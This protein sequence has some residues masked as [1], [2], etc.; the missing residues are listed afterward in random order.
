M[1]TSTDIAM[2]MSQQNSMFMGQQS[3]AQQIGINPA[4]MGG[5]QGHGH[6]APFSYGAGGLTN[7][8]YQQGNRFAGAAMSAMGAGATGVGLGLSAMSMF[9]RMGALAPLLDPISGGM[10]GFARAG[11]MGAIGGAA[12]PLALG[13]AAG[14]VVGSFVG[15]GQQ[16]QMIGSQLGQFQFF[17]SA[18]R[19]GMGFTRQD[20]MAIGDSIRQLAHI[21]EMMTSVEELTKLLPKLKSAGMMQG[22]KDATEFAQR[23]KDSIKTIRDVSKMLGTTMEEASEMFAHSRSVGFLGRQAQIQNVMNAQFTSGVTGMSVGQ[24][25]GMQQTGA[26]MALAMGARRSS[27]AMAV[28]NIAQQL[29]MAQRSG[30]LKEG[31]LEDITGLQGEE[32]VRAASERFAG[33]IASMATN[34]SV[35]R[36]SLLGLVKFDESGKAVGIDEDLARRYQ[37]GEVSLAEIKRKGMGLSSKQKLSFVTRERELAMDFAGKTGPQGMASFIEDVAGA[38]FGSEGVNL[39]LQRHGRMSSAEAD[40]FQGMIGQEDATGMRETMS[41]MREREAKIRERTDPQAILRRIKTRIH[42]S[43]LAGIEHAGAAYYNELGKAYDEFIDDLVGRHVV[44]LSQEGAKNFSMAMAGG[45]RG[46]LKKMFEAVHRS[47]GGSSSGPNAFETAVGGVVGVGAGVTAGLIAGVGTFGL[48]S[49]V[50]AAVGVGAMSATKHAL[51]GLRTGDTELGAMLRRQSFDTGRS[52]Q[53]QR[54]HIT[55]LMGN[56]AD[57]DQ[58][59]SALGEGVGKYYSG[60][61]R[62][63]GILG[64]IQTNTKE[65]FWNLN[66]QRK[67]DVMREGVRAKMDAGLSMASGHDA[68]LIK[69]ALMGDVAAQKVVSP[70]EVEK[71]ISNM[72]RSSDESLKDTAALLRSSQAMAKK[73]FKGVEAETAAVAAAQSGFSRGSHSRIDFTMLSSGRG[74]SM[75]ADIQAADRAV[76]DADSLLSKKLSAEAVVA[77][78]NKPEM[79]EIV[80]RVMS[81]EDPA[82]AEAIDSRDVGKALKTLSDKGLKLKAEDF[83]LLRNVIRESKAAGSGEVLGAIASYEDARNFADANVIRMQSANIAAEMYDSAKQLSGSGIDAGSVNDLSSALEEFSRDPSE[84]SFKNVQDR[85]TALTKKAA[86]ADETTRGKLLAAAGSFGR[87]IAQTLTDTKRL[88]KKVGKN[89]TKDELKEAYGLD[90]DFAKT[91]LETVSGGRDSV[92]ISENVIKDVEASVAGLRAGKEL[93]GRGSA[94]SSDPTV[95]MVNALKT[96]QK[97]SELQTTLLGNIAAENGG[98]DKTAVAVMI[99]AIRENANGAAGGGTDTGQSMGP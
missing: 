79:R 38:R 30:R 13:A 91:V 72:E 49:G 6:S 46:E 2:M 43:T 77:L 15:G 41:R 67:L 78:K 54:A 92:K 31:A 55:G 19:T 96:I 69:R 45:N 7:A 56:P 82:L 16:Q 80:R 90:D 1:L 83:D 3:F 99:A 50:G 66:E 40:V 89:L 28:T 74:A 60:M 47:R 4:G 14:Q 53:G 9:G 65:G 98:M 71:I 64:D 81:G 84:S 22:V 57:V 88:R 35:G 36:A 34:T 27:G 17:N 18:S 48:A 39:L 86:G 21:P 75:A 97:N 76:K 87:G 32:A 26:N 5:F 52:E 11:M 20:T 33:V 12:V 93:T 58:T 62:A 42:A 51:Y 44:T 73:G 59:A 85:V 70:E 94:A 23:F 25:M 8:T 68:G 24:V 95:E 37:Q 29:G 10:A 61:S 63:A